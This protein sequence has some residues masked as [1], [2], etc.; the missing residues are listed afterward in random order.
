MRC[1]QNAK[2]WKNFFSSIVIIYIKRTMR[3][4]QNLNWRSSYRVRSS[5]IVYSVHS[6]LSRCHETLEFQSLR[7]S[8]T[9]KT[10]TV[11]REGF[12]FQSFLRD[13]VIFTNRASPP[14]PSSPRVGWKRRDTKSS[15]SRFSRWRL[16]LI[17]FHGTRNET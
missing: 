4:I 1:K 9:I 3:Q 17:G 2:I 13:C 16:A 6:T 7:K 14:L 15:L 10:F 5:P 8:E 12:H 11:Q